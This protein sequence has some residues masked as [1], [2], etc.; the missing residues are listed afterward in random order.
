MIK[1]S[2]DAPA[3]WIEKTDMT[4]LS[5]DLFQSLHKEPKA[6]GYGFSNALNLAQKKSNVPYRAYDE[7]IRVTETDKACLAA[8]FAG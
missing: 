4:N 7:G 2:R 3:G 6:L 1:W 5:E 8:C